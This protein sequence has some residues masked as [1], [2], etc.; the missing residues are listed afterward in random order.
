MDVIYHLKRGLGRFAAAILASILVTVFVACGA[1]SSAQ[2]PRPRAG[3]ISGYVI[4]GPI[5]GASVQVYAFVGG[6][7]GALIGSAQT[8]HSGYFVLPAVRRATQAPILVEVTS[9][10]YIEDISNPGNAVN[11]GKDDILKAVGFYTPSAAVTLN[12]T[13]YTYIATG[14]AEYYI[15]QRMDVDTAIIQAN[16]A[17]STLLGAGID[18]LTTRPLRI[19]DADPGATVFTK[20]YAYGLYTGALSAYAKTI[21]EISNAPPYTS[22]TSIGLARRMYA[23]IKGDGIL[24]GIVHFNMGGASSTDTLEYGAVKLNSIGYRQGLGQGALKIAMARNDSVRLRFDEMM[25]Q[26]HAFAMSA[27]ALFGA[28]APLPFDDQPPTFSS[29]PD[30]EIIGIDRAQSSVTYRINVTDNV[31]VQRIS[32]TIDNVLLNQDITSNG[33]QIKIWA[34][35]SSGVGPGEHTMVVEALDNLGNKSSKSYI[36]TLPD[37]KPIVSIRSPELTNQRVYHAFG[38]FS[39]DSGTGIKS[40]S[41]AVGAQTITATLDATYAVWNADVALTGGVNQLQINIADNNNNS[42]TVMRTVTVDDLLPSV[43]ILPS[44]NVVYY[45]NNMQVAGNLSSANANSDPLYVPI[46]RIG[47]ANPAADATVL[48]AAQIPYYALTVGDNLSAASDIGV[49]V[50]YRLGGNIVTAKHPLRPTLDNA[51]VYVMPLI[52]QTLAENWYQ[53]DPGDVHTLE[54]EIRDKA[55]NSLTQIIAFKAFFD[56]PQLK[57]LSGMKNA[58]ALAHT[59]VDGAP[60]GQVGACNTDVSGQCTMRLLIDPQFLHVKIGGG[61]YFESATATEAKLSPD[62]YLSNVIDY[63]GGNGQVVVTP[64][65]HLGVGLIQNGVANGATVSAAYAQTATDLAAIYGFDVLTTVPADPGALNLTN[66]PLS[67]E[68]RYALL[69]AG[70]SDWTAQ[71]GSR[72]GTAPHSTYTSVS[73]AQKFYLDTLADGLLDGMALNANNQSQALMLGSVAIDANS[74]RHEIASGALNFVARNYTLSST[75]MQAVLQNVQDIAAN[76]H[77]KFAGQTPV[78]INAQQPVISVISAAFTTQ[79]NFA[80]KVRV[81]PGTVAIGAVSIG[82]VVA[83]GG[84]NNEWTATVT[85]AQQG[86]NTLAVRVLDTAASE[87][88]TQNIDVLLDNV[89]PVVKMTNPSSTANVVV[90]SANFSLSGTATDSS[91]IANVKVQIG[92][93][94]IDATGTAWA[95]N[96]V[97]TPGANSVS[98]VATDAL[99][100]TTTQNLSV[101]YSVAGPA[102]SISPVPAARIK[103]TRPQFSGAVDAF[104]LTYTLNAV[105]YAANGTTWNSLA[106]KTVVPSATN[107]WS[108]DMFT[109]TSITALTDGRY[110]L[111]LTANNSLNT[112]SVTDVIFVVDTLGPSIQLVSPQGPT[113]ANPYTL[114]VEAVDTGGVVSSLTVNSFAATSTANNHW[115]YL[116]PTY[117]IDGIKT[118]DV[119]AQDDLGNTSLTTLSITLDTTGPAL[120]IVKPADQQW[121]NTASAVVTYTVDDVS[122]PTSAVLQVNNVGVTRDA[123]NNV[124]IPN[125]GANMV[126]V[127]ASDGVG[128]QATRSVTVNRD[129]I[130]PQVNVITAPPTATAIANTSFVLKV[131]EVNLQ[132][133][134]VKISSVGGYAGTVDLADVTKA[135]TLTLAAGSVSYN[136]AT[137]QISGSVGLGGGANDISL[138]AYDFAAN[139][140]NVV[141][142]HSIVDTQ[143]PTGSI[144]NSGTV[145]G[146]SVT[147]NQTALRIAASDVNTGNSGIQSVTF[148]GGG[149]A[150]N[151][152]VNTGQS[153]L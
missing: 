86:R 113:R 146:N 126:T 24:D 122:L 36:I 82:G 50:Q 147:T 99:G 76:P 40:I 115:T 23:D 149:N 93:Q 109:G 125:E 1:G 54:F 43:N 137:G 52:K 44:D 121:V 116:T 141:I 118:F 11:L 6:E 38:S 49:S 71:V 124:V 45:R 34:N 97:L 151:L 20:E 18:V 69:L 129:T 64:Y 41:V 96:L 79:A 19:I 90:N 72:N 35:G 37:G 144:G 32:V 120:V 84:A 95:A 130:L 108:L 77:A 117:T 148:T 70:L 133:I 15:S 123:Q 103:N 138:E 59:F 85:L 140:S 74:Y 4:D 62:E 106:Q 112:A 63:R 98:I 26:A 83:T 16:A 128:N 80:A 134:L 28:A 30:P 81:T 33:N 56:L 94:T 145:S 139:R 13:P 132:R 88:L 51:A 55:G 87:L 29:D 152:S 114:T 2:P 89:G 46:A 143:A 27:D 119:R 14:L 57:I 104:G 91:G 135:A 17:V 127:I 101:T 131:T 31:G 150:A 111:S 25:H 78:T 110:K 7:K 58:Q 100:N 21:S 61:S 73:A 39:D 53:A 68:V 42:R 142:F 75:A 10:F 48:S 66:P 12:I 47:F 22:Y 105:L 65:T 60:G 153:G 92:T 107:A 136:S 5:K 8:D 3:S 102:V 9:G 67:K